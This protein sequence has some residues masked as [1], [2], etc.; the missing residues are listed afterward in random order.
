M[1]GSP[2]DVGE[3]LVTYV[4]QRK[5]CTMSCDIGEAVEGLE[6]EADILEHC[7]ILVTNDFIRLYSY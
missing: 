4:K 7:L 5:S 6:N 1:G 2:G 3:V